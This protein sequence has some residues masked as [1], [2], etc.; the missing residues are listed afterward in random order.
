MILA[1]DLAVNVDFWRWIF[2]LA[3]SEKI[4]CQKSAVKSL[5]VVFRLIQTLPTFWA[6]RILIDMFVLPVLDQT[7]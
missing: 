6:T 2:I 3:V 4:R 7:F 5:W 1:V